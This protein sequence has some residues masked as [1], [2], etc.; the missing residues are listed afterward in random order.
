LKIEKEKYRLAIQRKSAAQN[1]LN[2]FIEGFFNANLPE[3]FYKD[4]LQELKD[5]YNIANLLEKEKEKTIK[6]LTQWD[7][8]IMGLSELIKELKKAKEFNQKR[9]LILS[10]VN[11]VIINWDK[12]SLKHSIKIIYKVD[13]MMQ[14]VVQSNITLTYNKSG[15]CL[16]NETIENALEIIVNDG[17]KENV[18]VIV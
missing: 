14:Y 11:E 1:R 16:S 13:S 10:I 9:N 12:A 5:E 2:I 6:T 18:K 7:D 17:I 4:K 8:I 3:D 15:F